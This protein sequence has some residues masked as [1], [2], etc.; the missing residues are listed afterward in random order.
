MALAHARLPVVR[1][2]SQSTAWRECAAS[3]G[4]CLAA[5]LDFAEG[6]WRSVA[7]LFRGFAVRGA[8][9]ERGDRRMDRAKKESAQRIFLFAD[10]GR[11]WVVRPSRWMDSISAARVSLWFVSDGEANGGQP[12][13]AAAPVRLLAV[14]PLR[15]TCRA[16]PLDQADSGET[17]PVRD[18][19]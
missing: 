13:I 1:A 14:T 5:V 2:Q 19:R 15:G 17:P 12:A 16:S 10:R 9:T 11:I 3:R 6:N 4:E 7:Q 18:E 8:S